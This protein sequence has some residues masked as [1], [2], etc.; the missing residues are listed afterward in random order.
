MADV[1]FFFLNGVGPNVLDVTILAIITTVNTPLDC[2]ARARDGTKVGPDGG[3]E[4]CEV[5]ARINL[6]VT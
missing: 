4:E 5:Q 6:P 2:R 1:A 3:P